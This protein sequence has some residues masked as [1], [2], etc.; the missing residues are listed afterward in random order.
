M[1]D[2]EMKEVKKFT[3][4]RP[5][6]ASGYNDQSLYV[7]IATSEIAV[8]PVDAGTK[9]TFTG[10]KGYDLWMLWNAEGVL[11]EMVRGYGGKKVDRY[12]TDFSE[13]EFDK[14]M[15]RLAQVTDYL[16]SGMLQKSS[17]N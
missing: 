9:A 15:L 10:G 5:A 4:A 16:R 3:Y 13:E 7:N 14:V 8:K 6:I 12:D 1:P 2:F 17:G 11:P